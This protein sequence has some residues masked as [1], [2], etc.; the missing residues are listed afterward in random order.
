MAGGFL[1]RHDELPVD[2]ARAGLRFKAG[3]AIDVFLHHPSAAMNR[4]AARK[5][6]RPKVAL[7]IESSRA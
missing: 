6:L 2:D 5:R 4:S 3:N 1:R 7:I